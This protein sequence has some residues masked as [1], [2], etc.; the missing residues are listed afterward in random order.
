MNIKFSLKLK[1]FETITLILLIVSVTLLTN[2]P[3]AKAQLAAEQPTAG[4][5]KSGVT[6]SITV[7]TMSFLSFRPNPVGV[8]QIILVNVWTEPP[9]NV[10]RNL[11]G[12]HMVTI[13]KPDGTTE[14][15]GPLNSYAGDST[16]WFEYK[17][18]QVGTYKIKFDFLGEYYPV[19]RYLNGYIVTNTSGTPL[20]S[21]YYKPS[22]T[23]EQTLTVQQDMVASWPPAPLPTDY[24]TRP[25][26]AEN[27]EWWPISGNYPGTGVV[28]GG[29]NW[30]ENTNPIIQSTYGFTPYV[31][32][33][34]TAHV[35]YRQQGNIAG[36]IGGT[37]GQYSSGSGPGT[38]SVIYAGRCYQTL[39]MQ[40]DNV[41]TSY[42]LCYDLRT[43]KQYY[44]IPVALGGITPTVISYY[45]PTT[46]SVA[47]SGD[48]QT[49][50]VSLML[51]GDRLI[52]INPWTGAVT[53]NVT[54]MTG[55]FY[56]D[57]YVLSIQ[58]NN[59]AAGTRLINWTTSGTST[60]FKTRIVSN[61]S[62]PLT[63]LGYA[64]FDAGIA[65]NKVSSTPNGTGISANWQL[66][67]A[68]LTTGQL[69]WN[70]T[71]NA[72]IYNL[73]THVADHGKVALL[74]MTGDAAGCWK[75]WDLS[76]GKELWVSEKMDYPWSSDAFGA[77][78]VQS[79]YGMFYRMSYDAVFAFNWNNG[80]IVWKYEAPANP[81]ETPYIN[82]NGST[83]YSWNSNGII[84]DGKLYVAN[85][86]HSPT[87]PITR[88]WRLHCINATT[89]K[90]IW[91]IT[92]SWGTPGAIADGY[93]TGSNGYDGYMYVFGKGE[94]ATTVSAPQTAIMQGQSMVLTGTVL[95]QSP[96]KSD[97]ACVSKE[98][99]ATYME[100]LYM[101]KSIPANVNM[102]GVPVSLDAVDP[103]GNSVHI[104]TVASDMSGTFGYTWAPTIA[105]QYKITATFV[106]DDSYGSSWAQTY[107][108][109]T[110][111]PQATVTP[112]P[113]P[114]QQ[115]STD[116]YIA[117]STI[118][119]IIAIAIA[120]LLLRKRP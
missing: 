49:Y 111:A 86:E 112:T 106:G 76:S 54:G 101:Q 52:K 25:I 33:P 88:G 114:V 89:G 56:A 22:S 104:A 26:S 119:I 28:G 13:T 103:N 82:E 7:D 62:F 92:G 80:K 24:W 41:P 46:G 77:Y 93:L 29:T 44:A 120:I 36:L 110:E 99:M 95:D 78:G 42:A 32:A 90:G 40:T 30:P 38:P 109:V 23:S 20:D 6:P 68:S 70:I 3:N 31:Q 91:N 65:T 69:L 105:G 115:S 43:G 117:G 37:A 116:L 75:C 98:S 12:T 72:K 66:M 64:D 97:V 118:A 17:V 9:I 14:T 85:S 63:T 1:T 81:Y 73:E 10:A 45:R 18:D 107:A 74:M 96:A 16:A 51:I 39:T 27:R 60:D 100:Y 94:S 79:A 5:L 87:Y 2:A 84:A 61:I 48:D 21:A 35:V 102:T 15:V 34:N 59:T 55:T 47:G 19:G 83:I 4:P 57:P 50:T 58:T 113:S 71:L 53:L 11:V 67:A 108:A 8:G